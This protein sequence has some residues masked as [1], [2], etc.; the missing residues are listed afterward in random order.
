MVL[1]ERVYQDALA[2]GPVSQVGEQRLKEVE[3]QQQQQQ[4]MPTYNRQHTSVH[5]PL[6]CSLQGLFQA[7]PVLITHHLHVLRAAFQGSALVGAIVCRLEAL[8]SSSRQPRSG[9]CRAHCSIMH[10][11][12]WPGTTTAQPSTEPVTDSK[13]PAV[14]AAGSSSICC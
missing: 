11:G 6:L 7:T 4:L 9:L 12:M 1:Q 8:V 14:Q 5:S 10:C 13:S 3:L 2:C